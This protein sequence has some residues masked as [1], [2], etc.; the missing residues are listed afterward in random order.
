MKA[1]SRNWTQRTGWLDAPVSERADR[2][3]EMFERQAARDEYLGH[4]ESVFR[5]GGHIDCDPPDLED[6][7]D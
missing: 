4:E 7:Y 1:L 5:C 6:C 2:L 3:A